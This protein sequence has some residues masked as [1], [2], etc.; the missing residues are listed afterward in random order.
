MRGEGVMR[1]APEGKRPRGI[2][3]ALTTGR[4]GGDQR[5]LRSA[6]SPQETARTPALP[7]P[8]ADCFVRSSRWATRFQRGAFP[9]VAGGP[10]PRGGQQ[11]RLARPAKQNVPDSALLRGKPG[12]YRRSQGPAGTA[13][14]QRR[15]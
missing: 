2:A 12:A 5:C 3:H 15:P 13:A 7:L 11:H 14:I 8:P 10:A 9:V 1:K 6:G 4:K